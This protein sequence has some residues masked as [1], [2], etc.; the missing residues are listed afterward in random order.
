MST[1][2]VGFFGLLLVYTLATQLLPYVLGL[3]GMDLEPSQ[4]WYPWN[5]SPVMAV[6]MFL[7]AVLPDRRWSFALPLLML[8]VRDFGIWALSGRFDW[9]FSPSTPVIY[10]CFAAAAAAGL[11]LRPRRSMLTAFPMAI[12]AETVFFLVTNFAVWCGNEGL[13]YPATMTGL[14]LCYMAGIP[15]FGRS[16]LSTSLFSLVL[17]SPLGLR[18]A[19][20]DPADQARVVTDQSKSL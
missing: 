8:L 6:T 18:M 20:L 1:N 11:F 4:N 3:L 5:F 17:F 16:L 15:F 13:N 2:R 12:L 19:G 9:A 14:G 10:A 7:G